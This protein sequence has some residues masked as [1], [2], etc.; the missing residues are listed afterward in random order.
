MAK[1]SLKNGNVQL[2]KNFSLKEFQCKDGSDTVLVEGKLVE[3]LQKLRERLGKPILINSAYRTPA[4]NKRVG[5]APKSQHMLGL[6]ADVQVKGLTPA[7][8]AEHAKAVGFTG[9]GLYDTF[10]HIDVRSNVARWD[11]RSKK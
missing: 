5:G 6:A 7:Q 1:Y 3:K 2:S 10:T 8:V 4:Y 9:I 11:F